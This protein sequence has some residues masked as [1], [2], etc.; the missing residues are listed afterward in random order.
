M[1][2]LVTGGSGSGKSAYA[3]S[4]LSG[5]EHVD[6]RYYIATM[7]VYGEE[8]K[9]RVERHRKLRAGKGFVTI[10]QT[11]QIGEALEKF[12]TEKPDERVK[13]KQS[14]QNKTLQNRTQNASAALVECVSN[15]T[16]NEMF[17]ENGQRSEQ[18]VISRVVSGLKQL[19]RSVQE[20][21]IVT[22]NVFD[23]GI[24]YDEST[25]A[26]IRA[27]ARINIELAKWADEVTEVTAGIPVIWKRKDSKKTDNEIACERN[28]EKNGQNN[29]ASQEGEQGWLS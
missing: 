26:Y 4:L 7:Q 5:F 8:G 11:V 14:L 25:M 2:Y 9:K 12:W 28:S 18:E 27:L 15:L 22:N 1:V 17:D 20:L 3:E 23:D 6:N 21:V 10:E 16:A 29:K 19:S 24:S 13:E